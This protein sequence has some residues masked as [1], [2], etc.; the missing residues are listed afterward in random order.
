[1]ELTSPNFQFLFD[2]DPAL[3]K[4]AA[5]AERYCLTDPSSSLAKLRLFGEFLAKNIA[6]RIGVYTGEFHDQVQVIKELKYQ[7]FLDYNLSEM[8]QS[9]RRAGNKAVHEGL[10]TT[11]EALQNLRFAHQLSV[12]FFRV[13]KNKAFKPGA[14]QIPPNPEDATTELKNELDEARNQIYQL[15]EKVE[16]VE[17]LTQEEIDKRK[18][19]EEESSK[20]WSELDAA[21]DLA[22][23][24]EE[25]AQ[26]EI[27]LYEKELEELQNKATEQPEKEIQ[28]TISSSKQEA[29]NI[30]LTEADT[31][32]LIDQQLRDAGWDAD[33]EKIRFSEGVRP[34][35]GVNK[36]IAEWPTKSGPADYVLFVGLQAIGIVE[37]KRKNLDVSS[38]IDQAKRYCRDFKTHDSCDLEGGPWDDNQIPFVFSTNGRPFLRQM[39]TQS[40]I[41]FCDVRRPQNLRR[42]LE[43][44]Y[45]PQGL[46]DLSRIDID[47]A[48]LK[49]DQMTFSFG[50]PL[51]Y[52]QKDAIIE[53][54]KAIRE[55]KQ[56][57]L[58]AMA[59]GTGKTKTSIA[60][61]FRLL[62]AQRFRRILF[63]VDMI[64]LGEQASN[65]FKDTEMVGLQKFAD[66]FAIKEL[67][68]AIPDRETAVHI[69]TIQGMVKR[70]LYAGD[71]ELKPKVDQYD[72]IIVD[73]CHRGYLLDRE[74]SDVE[75][76]FRSQGDYISKYRR[77]IDYFDAVKIGL[78][79]TPALHTTDI[80]GPPIYSYSYREGVLDGYLVDHEPPYR[81]KTELSEKGV[82][83]DKD[84]QVKVLNTET[85]EIELHNTPDELGFDVSEFNKS[86]ITEPF[87]QV[88]CEYLAKELDPSL[89]EKTLIFCANDRHADLVV[90]LL[91]K[92]FKKV[93]G[94]IEDD[95]VKKI[96]G[97]AD[98]PLELI[99]KYKNEKFPNVAVTV[100]LLT[101]GIDVLQ[102]CNLVFIRKVNSRIL[103]DQM[104]GRA[105]RR[106]D[107][108]GKEVFRVYDAVNIYGGLQDYTD[109][110][111]VVVNPKITFKQLEEEIRTIADGEMKKQ[112]RDQFI[113]KLQARKR[114]LDENQKQKF[115]I[116]TD[117]T[118]D[119]FII[120]ILSQPIDKVLEWFQKNSDIGK[121]L[122]I[123]SESGPVFIPISEETDRVK[124]V[125][126]GYGDGKATK[127]E[128]YIE[129]F[130]QFI[131]ESRND[132]AAL[133]II[134]QRPRNLTRKKLK[135]LQLKLEMQGFRERDLQSAYKATSNADI[136]AG[137]I[138]FIRQAAL[139]DALISWEQRVDNA[140]QGILASTEW[141][142]P[143]ETWLKRIATQMKK[144]FIVDKE[145]MNSAQFRDVGGFNRI[146]RVFEGKLEQI[147]EDINE[148]VWKKQA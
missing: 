136:A 71:E 131:S 43:S 54:E 118:P 132:I 5:M 143:Q 6:A 37:A 74:M 51:R 93:Y 106:C 9:I 110:K 70:I 78:T 59:T 72:C 97:K 86:V 19:A 47:D 121:I 109:M 128:D 26:Q 96:T 147:L 108:I 69:S 103:F 120:D 101:T 99:R 44:W 89:D 148:L 113:A 141:T 115:K 1:M 48:E 17:K 88:V 33:T 137:I 46:I 24:T 100:V 29:N 139:G 14:F 90:N 119:E 125:S 53:T 10:G 114:F 62:K 73:E 145:S 105:T 80:F 66:I 20:A 4:Q 77:T 35:R 58:L 94:E 38:A 129:G 107:E 92:E 40:G 134:L 130:K 49:L 142:K 123:K 111:P 87:N 67:G 55:G 57:A 122:D 64:A 56:Q 30:K 91:K 116:K 16:D 28:E 60:L 7:G 117:K 133:K 81:I 32:I 68:D 104:L 12:H 75:L 42:P 126:I 140:V 8:F 102:I 95:A 138:G 65:A 76:T 63:I 50:F 15:Q 36:A 98:K 3:V 61:I 11:K 84:S 25:Q 52:Y 79:A 31:R 146:N 45:T 124:E 39:E 144:E 34:E 2:L 135:E 13:F 22:Q 82:H 127:P 85:G 41:W 27:S 18:L 112:A 23:Q 21:L 83:W